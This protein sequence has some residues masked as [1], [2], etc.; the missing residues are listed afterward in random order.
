MSG[1]LEFGEEDRSATLRTAWNLSLHL[2]AS[3]VST[4]TF[5]GFIVPIQPLSYENNVVTLGV[6]MPYAKDRLEHN[7]LNAIRSAL[8]FHLDTTGLQVQFVISSREQQAENSRK[9]AAAASTQTALPLDT[10]ADEE[11]DPP[12]VAARADTPPQTPSVPPRPAP[13]SGS[14]KTDGKRGGSN[15]L[16]DIPSM[17]LNDRFT[18]DNFLGGGR[19]NRLAFASASAVA[20]RP[21]DVYNPLF[22]Y[23][24]PGLGKTHLLQ[25]IA[26]AIHVRHPKMRI[27]YVSGEYFTQH[28]VSSLQAKFTE[29][30]RR[31]YR[32]VD[33][34]LVDDIQ[35]IAGKE[36]TKEEFFH[37]FSALYQTGKQIVLASDRSPRELNTMD[38]R[39]RS[40][41]QSGL[42]ADISAPELETR[43]AFLQKCREREGVGVPDDVLLYIADAIQ[44]NMRTLEGALTRLIAYCSIMNQPPTQEVAQGVLSEYFIG[45]PIR[46]RKVTIDEIVEAVAEQFQTTSVQIKGPGRHK[47]IAL[48]RHVAM[49]LCRELMP[50]LNTSI[51][52]TAFGGRDHATIVYACQ[53]IRNLLQAD[54]ELKAL[55]NQ[56]IKS[57]TG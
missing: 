12:N 49:H 39:L 17:P 46:V 31:Q 1:Q 3:K 30:F 10:D 26:H 29:E 21:G 54:P 52:G 50:E 37:T 48:A 41:F 38:E 35:F 20:E 14:R 57:L 28:Y 44:S 25:S 33:V 6:S 4:S 34:W 18:F 8:E 13:K 43:I 42:I 45:K 2:L 23:G 5:Q 36:Q 32:A 15:E 27:A 24:G 55:V 7:H 51:T 56:L 22:L 11:A 19:S 9:T 47:D 53:R 16:P 40:R